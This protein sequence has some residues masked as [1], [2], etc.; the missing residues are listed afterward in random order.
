[1]TTTEPS[2]P[3]D[4]ATVPPAAITAGPDFP[5]TTGYR[6]TVDY[7]DF[8]AHGRRFTQA[9]IVLTP[10]TPRR[11]HGR[12]I[13]VI[14]GEGGSDN[15]RGFLSSYDG[16]EGVGPW[17]ARRG[18]TFVALARIGRWNF[19][20]ADRSGSWADIPIGER[21]PIFDVD[22]RS[23]WTAEDYETVPVTGIS[24]PT[25][26]ERARVPREGTLLHAQMLAASPEALVLGYR[27][28][29]AHALRDMRREEVLLL[30]WGFST[31]GAV[32][33]PLARHIAPD[34]YLGW[35]TSS[36]GI[37]YFYSRAIHGRF[38]WAYDRSAL[39]VRERGWRD[40]TFYTRHIDEETRRRW[41]RSAQGAPRFKSVE[42]AMMFYNVGALTEHAGRLW[43]TDFLPSE[44][45]RGGFA[46]FARQFLDPSFPPPELA[47]VA[48]L[49]VNGTLDEVLPPPIV[50]ATRAVMEPY[51]RRY[52]VVRIDGFHHDIMAET[53][54]VVGRLWLRFIEAGWFDPAPAR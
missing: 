12:R 20:A 1:V 14:A 2:L 48:A 19:L 43:N 46:A 31:G 3:A 7:V 51:C 10:E 54:A 13:V 17:L 38:D 45:R 41:W 30:Y 4:G 23:Y 34:G 37:A 8:F 22:Q 52:R 32:L 50:D 21:M 5:A 44:E 33:W 26:S 11:H 9:A 24:S 15:G 25:E 36:P 42:D 16:A 49:Q 47:S 29:V 40:F 53:M 39:R 27:A 6:R 18:I 35:G 28:G